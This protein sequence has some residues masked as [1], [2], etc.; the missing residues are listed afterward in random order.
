M[1]RFSYVN[2]RFLP[3][4]QA[5][6]HVEDRGYQFGDG[7]YE[8]VSVINR[9]LIDLNEHIDRLDRS[10]RELQIDW[11]V[12]R[13]VLSILIRQILHRNAIKNGIVYLQI[14][15]GVAPRDHKFP[16]N[17]SPSLIMT[18][19]KLNH[20]TASRY[21][22]GAKVVTIPDI[23]WARCDIKSISLLP[24]CLGKQTAY[25]SGA[26]EAWLVNEDGLITE[27]TSSNAWIVNDDGQLLT[28]PPTSEILNGITRLAILKLA[29]ANGIEFI[30][31]PFSVSEAL[32]AREAFTTSAT[33]FVTPIV[34]IDDETIGD[35]KPGT[36]SK[37]L[38]EHY[39]D[40]IGELSTF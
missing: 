23:R 6:I 20:L 9:R 28:R 37:A 13:N 22:E 1:P 18:T 36:L 3:H 39:K 15:R 35:G 17:T 10:L 32:S 33:S 12:T 24:N 38:M 2:G 40:Y 11:P 27:G 19:K 8:V 16:K 5:A 34:T 7:V 26:Y 25:E 21:Y 30:E 4:T 14:T 31:R 29:N